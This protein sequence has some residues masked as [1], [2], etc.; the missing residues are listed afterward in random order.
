MTLLNKQF[1]GGFEV[2]SE[3]KEEYFAQKPL[4]GFEQLLKYLEHYSIADLKLKTVSNWNFVFTFAKTEIRRL[5][6]EM[7]KDL[8]EKTGVEMS[9][10]QIEQC[11]Y[12][13][14]MPVVLK[15]IK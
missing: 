10:L 5:G 3:L 14:V 12:C 1:G 13:L 11:G 8:K 9:G 7:R 6:T 2:F 15:R 4:R